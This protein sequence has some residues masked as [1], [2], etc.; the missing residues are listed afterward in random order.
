MEENTLRSSR[1]WN[2]LLV[3][4]LREATLRLRR[5]YDS[6]MIYDCDSIFCLCLHLFPFDPVFLV[7]LYGSICNL[8]FSRVTQRLR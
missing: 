3:P 4:L 8:L 2:L 1:I 6:L 5:F 7:T